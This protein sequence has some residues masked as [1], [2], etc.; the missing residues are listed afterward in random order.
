MRIAQSDSTALCMAALTVMPACRMYRAVARYGYKE[1]VSLG[2]PA[3][4]ACS[5]AQCCLQQGGCGTGTVAGPGSHSHMQSGALSLKAQT[6]LSRAVLVCSLGE[7]CMR[8]RLPDCMHR[9]PAWWRGVP[10]S[11]RPSFLARHARLNL[12]HIKIEGLWAAGAPFQAQLVGA[13][14]RVFNCEEDSRHGRPKSSRLTV[15]CWVS[16]VCEYWDMR[17]A[18]GAAGSPACHLAQQI[19]GCPAAGSAA[20]WLP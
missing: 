16:F 2:S 13:L 3:C 15:S 4:R 1:I 6:R 5:A 19:H 20:S 11:R 7:G 18:V 10:W 8:A 9:R 17:D 12:D 14:Y